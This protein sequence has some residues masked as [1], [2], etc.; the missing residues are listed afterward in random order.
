M[1]SDFVLPRNSGTTH[2]TR[3]CPV[4][5][6]KGHQRKRTHVQNPCLDLIAVGYHPAFQDLTG[7]LNLQKYREVTFNMNPEGFIKPSAFSASFCN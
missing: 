7:A 2:F 5:F 6:E 4:W 3:D 1:Q